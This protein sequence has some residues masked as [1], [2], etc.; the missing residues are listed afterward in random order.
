MIISAVA[1]SGATLCASSTVQ[2]ALADVP[3][4]DGNAAGEIPMLAGGN[5]INAASASGAV[6]LFADAHAYAMGVDARSLANHFSA[7]AA[8]CGFNQQ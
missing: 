6:L 4:G 2:V 1:K 3:T 5:L 8:G 7:N